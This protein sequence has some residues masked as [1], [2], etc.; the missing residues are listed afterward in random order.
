MRDETE[1][2]IRETTEK[3]HKMTEKG[4]EEKVISGDKE[5]E[6]EIKETGQMR[7]TRDKMDENKG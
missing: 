2:E 1:K 3:S 6:T 5:K 7:A 4:T